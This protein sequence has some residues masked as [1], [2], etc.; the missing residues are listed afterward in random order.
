LTQTYWIAIF[1]FVSATQNP[2]E[3]DQSEI[4]IPNAPLFG[5]RLLDMYG[6]SLKF[7]NRVMTAE[8]G[9]AARKVPAHMPHFL[10][11]RVIEDMQTT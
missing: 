4:Y 3:D 10:Q 2:H 11:K 6:D 7:V 1:T 5:R 9:P 8:F